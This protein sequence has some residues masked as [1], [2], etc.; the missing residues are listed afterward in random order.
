MNPCFSVKEPVQGL[1]TLAG[2]RVGFEF[3]VQDAP[4]MTRSMASACVDLN[5]EKLFV[6][7]PGCKGY[8]LSEVVEV[9]SLHYLMA[10]LPE[11]HWSLQTVSVINWTVH[12]RRAASTAH[13]T[14]AAVFFA[15]GC[16]RQC[17]T[18]AA[19]RST[20][21]SPAFTRVGS[22]TIKHPLCNNIYFK[23]KSAPREEGPP[24]FN[25]SGPSLAKLRTLTSPTQNA[26]RS[27]VRNLHQENPQLPDTAKP[28][29]STQ[30]TRYE[31]HFPS[32][33]RLAAWK[34]L[35]TS[36]GRRQTHPS[37]KRTFCGSRTLGR[38]CPAGKCLVHRGGR[39]SV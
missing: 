5:L 10:R 12:A 38:A 18:A 28:R 17:A 9:I 8:R 24:P 36:R 14:H 2:K 1:S 39:R 35:R 34:T 33:R 23:V 16:S 7:T 22:H 15:R 25:T 19:L 27:S 26:L 31:H 29:N 21:S 3:K 37:P 4:T 13:G 6:V 20:K 32:H 30:P 11:L